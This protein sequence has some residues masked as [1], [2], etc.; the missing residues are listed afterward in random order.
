MDTEKRELW[1]RLENEPERAYRAFE[2]YLALPSGER[3]LLEAYR[4]HVGNPHAVKPSDTWSGWSRQFAWRE[5]AAPVL[6]PSPT[7]FPARCNRLHHHRNRRLA[8]A[9]G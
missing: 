1:D 6:Q 2:S 9:C 5:R 3:T 8:L 7:L 4:R